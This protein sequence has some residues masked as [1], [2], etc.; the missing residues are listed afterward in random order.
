MKLDEQSRALSAAFDMIGQPVQFNPT[1]VSP[2]NGNDI[3]EIE[4][5]I[6]TAQVRV[7]IDI[8]VSIVSHT[9]PQGPDILF[10]LLR[11]TARDIDVLQRIADNEK[12]NDIALA[13]NVSRSTI[14]RT[15]MALMDMLG[16]HSRTGL[17]RWYI[18]HRY[19]LEAP[20]APASI[21]TFV[22]ETRRRHDNG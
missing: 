4:C 12:Y 7:R 11:A 18:Q 14:K 3:W 16:T 15:A 21:R 8:P 22:T 20:G 6:G 5:L 1:A 19:Q 17:V 13:L 2:P 9:D 10:P